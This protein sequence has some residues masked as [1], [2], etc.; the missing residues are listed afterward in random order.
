MDRLS[1]EREL[2][3]TRFKVVCYADNPKE[4]EAAAAEA[5]RVAE[6][7]EAVASDYLPESELSKLTRVQAGMSVEVSPLLYELLDHSLRVAEQTEG[8]FDPTLGTLSRLWRKTRDSKILPKEAELSSAKAVAGWRHLVLDRDQRTVIFGQRGICLDLGGVAKGYAADLMFETMQLRG[9]RQVMVA[10]G[11]DIRVGDAPPDRT[12]WRIALQTL[13]R[14]GTD[15]VVELEN[16]AVSTSGDLY[17]WVDVDGVRYSHILDPET[18]LGLTNR[19][20]AVVI[21]DEA[22]WSD[23]LATAACVLG[24]PRLSVLEKISGVREVRLRLP[25]ETFRLFREHPFSKP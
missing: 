21:A 5:F 6:R 19:V 16:A 18:G 1:Y 14:D 17:Q 3:G 15:G 22:K 12:G 2:M 9:F 13:E 11:G 25:Q 24:R 23:P 4:A 7:I 8:T 20:A 10:A